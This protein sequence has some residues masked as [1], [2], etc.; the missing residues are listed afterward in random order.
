LDDAILD[1]CA[2]WKHNFIFPIF[3]NKKTSDYK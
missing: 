3:K 1:V 2:D